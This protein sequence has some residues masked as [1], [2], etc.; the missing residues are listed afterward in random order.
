MKKILLTV[1]LCL[2]SSVLYASGAANVAGQQYKNQAAQNVAAEVQPGTVVGKKAFAFTLPDV[3]GKNV[4]FNYKD[5]VSPFR[6]KVSVIVFFA[7][8]CP[9]CKDELPYVEKLYK[10]YS[11]NSNVKFIG[12]STF[13]RG[14]ADETRGFATRYRLDFPVVSDTAAPLANKVADQY[15][16][17]GV[18]TILIADKTGTIRYMPEIQPSSDTYIEEMSQLIDSLAGAKAS[19]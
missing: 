8:W 19:K 6:S 16:I 14:E 3:S 17:R 9:H 7:T 5:P 2:I 1:F 10:K 13:L 18:P 4:V 12:I 11:N 15:R